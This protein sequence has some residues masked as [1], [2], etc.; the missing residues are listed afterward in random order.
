VNSSTSTGERTPSARGTLFAASVFRWV[1]AADTK[2]TEQTNAPA[3]IMV[4]MCTTLIAP[5][6]RAANNRQSLDGSFFGKFHCRSRVEFTALTR[7]RDFAMVHY[8]SCED[9]N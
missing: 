7:P 5:L 4:L 1:T 8:V 2:I 9:T 6:T 3:K